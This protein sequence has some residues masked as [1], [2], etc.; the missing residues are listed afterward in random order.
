MNSNSANDFQWSVMIKEG[1]I[2]TGITSELQRKKGW[3]ED[4]DENAIIYSPCYGT[5]WKNKRKVQGDI[6][7][8][9]SGDEIHFKFSPK[10]KKFSISIVCL[11]MQLTLI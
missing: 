5:I 11:V 9:E 2:R 1:W 3:I 10:L 4:F 7:K 8:L 6:T